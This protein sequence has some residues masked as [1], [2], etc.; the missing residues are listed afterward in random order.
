MS[1]KVVCP[2]PHPTPQQWCPQKRN[3]EKK[4]LLDDLTTFWRQS[5]KKGK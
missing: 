3:K 4:K 1:S 5:K 2:L